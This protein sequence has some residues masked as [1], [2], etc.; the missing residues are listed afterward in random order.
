LTELVQD[1]IERYRQLYGE[2]PSVVVSAPGRV[3]LIGEHTDYNDGFVLPV[4]IDRKIVIAAGKRNDM[5][6]RLHSVDLLASADFSLDSI[7]YHDEHLWMNYTAGVAY[8]FQKRKYPLSGANMC[9]RGNIPIGAGLSSSAALSVASVLALSTLNDVKISHIDAISLAQ[10]SETEF[11]GV[12]CGI[13]DQFISVM[14]KKNHALFLDCKSLKYEHVP[15]P[16]GVRLVICDTGSRRELAYS[17]YNQRRAECEDAVRQLAKRFHG[18]ASLREITREQLPEIESMLSPI[19][20]K[21]TFHVVTENDRV[22]K[23]VEALKKDDMNQFGKLMV[24]SHNSLKYYYEVSS[25][26]LDAFVDI[27]VEA[28]GVF[29][30]RMTG[31]GFGGSAICIVKNE[32]VDD[33]VYRLRKEFPKRAGRSLTIYISSIEDGAMVFNPNNLPA[34]THAG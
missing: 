3:N 20:R 6:I 2:S 11:V 18:I 32:N 14:G 19:A 23:S 12:Q 33:L 34:P 26:E 4:A 24:E 7:H 27:A 10:Q 15:F 16:T 1:T 28:E 5:H 29:G 8:I 30:A 17:A 21:R 13:M 25:K 22:L 9:I 31:A